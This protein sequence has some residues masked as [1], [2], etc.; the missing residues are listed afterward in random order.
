M[1]NRKL[2]EEL[3]ELVNKNKVDWH[4]LKAM[5]EILKMSVQIFWLERKLIKSNK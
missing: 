2:W 4:G 3:E 1:K 5:L